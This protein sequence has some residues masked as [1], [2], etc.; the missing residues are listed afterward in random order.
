MLEKR[1]KAVPTQLFA[2][3]GTI[4]GVV[5]V[6]DTSLFKVKQQVIVAANSLPNLDALEVKNIISTTQMMIGLQSTNIFLPIDL[7]AYTTSLAAKIFANEQR[8]PTI[9]ADDFERAC[10]EEEP[11]VAK[12]VV[13]VDKYGDKYDE[14]NPLPIAF[15]GTIS[16]GDV[17]IKD[18]DGDELQVNNDGSINVNVVSSPSSSPGLMTLYQEV[19]SVVSGV[20]TTMATY[21][22]PTNGFKLYRINVSGDNIALFTLS[23]AGVVVAVKRT[24]FGNLNE[25][26][27]FEPFENGLEVLAGDQLQVTVIHQRP[28]IADFEVTIMGLNL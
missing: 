15:D 19:S 13:M 23:V 10:Y 17:Q 18:Q 25:N 1:F 14:N 24:F 12:R 16:I 21:I 20:E 9:T 26:F 7:S 6:V 11:T 22:A 28:F 8:R 27:I 5:T 4:A 2:V 3:S